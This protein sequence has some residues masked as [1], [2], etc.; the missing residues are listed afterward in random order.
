VSGGVRKS[1]HFVLQE[2]EE[3]SCRSFSLAFVGVRA[4]T[5][6]MTSL[7]HSET[8]PLTF[9][10]SKLVIDCRAIHFSATGS[11]AAS[12]LAWVTTFP[13][14]QSM[15]IV[16][17]SSAPDVRRLQCTLLGMGCAVSRVTK[18]VFPRSQ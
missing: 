18:S 14:P 17:P 4:Y 12:V 3:G 1:F 10:A 6:F 2:K 5:H 16:L 11:T 7:L 8:A 9:S 13:E 15:H